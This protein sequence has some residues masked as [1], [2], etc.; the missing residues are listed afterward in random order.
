MKFL[1]RHDLGQ[2]AVKEIGHHLRTRGSGGHHFIER[3]RGDI[4]VHVV[5]DED[6]AILLEDFSDFI[7]PVD[8]S[9]DTHR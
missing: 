8:G 2:S 1:L 9:G 4:F 7:E 5:H 6:E 3:Y